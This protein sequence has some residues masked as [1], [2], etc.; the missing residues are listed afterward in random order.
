MWCGL[1]CVCQTGRVGYGMILV[2][3]SV[4]LL[5][6]AHAGLPNRTRARLRVVQC[7]LHIGPGPVCHYYTDCSK[8]FLEF[9]SHRLSAE[10]GIFDFQV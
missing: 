10:N 1:R 6:I 5:I 2:L 9:S 3:L 8:D 4:V 7:S